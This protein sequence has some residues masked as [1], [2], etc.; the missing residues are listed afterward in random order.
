VIKELQNELNLLYNGNIDERN[1]KITQEKSQG[2]IYY[3]N[4]PLTRG[5]ATLPECSTCKILRP[6]LSSHCRYCDNCIEGFDHHCNWIGNCVGQRN[7]RYFVGFL[8]TTTICCAWLCGSGIVYLISRSQNETITGSVQDIFTFILV[9]SL[10]ILFFFMCNVT[11]WH[12]EL[13]MC[14]QTLKMRDRDGVKHTPCKKAFINLYKF[15]SSYSPRTSHFD[16]RQVRYLA[17]PCC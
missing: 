12:I 14:G 9:I 17:E 3:N 2:D 7:H 1:Q 4:E 10:G 15:F 6:H 13:V 11:M 5:N 8:I 16:T